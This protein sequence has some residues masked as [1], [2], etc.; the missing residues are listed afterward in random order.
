MKLHKYVTADRIDVLKNEL[1]RF[2]QPSA[3]NDPWE[4]KPRTDHLVSDHD[5]EGIAAPLME[6]DAMVDAF[7]KALLNIRES[8]SHVANGV[9]RE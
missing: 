3:L 7:A 4:L 8:L 1:I 5:I 2:T 9:P 6:H